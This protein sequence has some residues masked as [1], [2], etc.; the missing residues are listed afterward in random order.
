MKTI[1]KMSSNNN[2][3][4]TIITPTTSNSKIIINEN[5]ILI[6]LISGG[7]AG[8]VAKTTVAPFERLRIMAQTGHAHSSSTLISAQRIFIDEGI[9]GFW[10]GN[11]INV[12]R[13]T[14]ARGALFMSNDYFKSKFAIYLGII[15]SSSSS[16]SSSL[17]TSK[18]IASK[19]PPWASFLSGSFAGVVATMTTYPLDVARTRIAGRPAIGSRY[20]S[21]GMF[22]TLYIIVREE[23]IRGW[24]RGSGPTIAGALPYEGIKFSVYDLLKK[25]GPQPIPNDPNNIP[26]SGIWKLVS[27]ALAGSVAGLFMFPNDTVRKLLQMQGS[28]GAKQR[29]S[30]AFDCWRQTYRYGGIARFYRG[31]APYVIRMMPNSAIQFGTYEFVKTRLELS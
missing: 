15:P 22:R 17:A 16:S 19:L 13:I 4:N 11:F 20:V 9:K 6:S 23:G 7:I 5:K 21:A 29:Y 25:I 27:G 2:S 30:S 1:Q 12:V 18:H 31:V 28:D 24:Y 10:R 26:L 14:P 3:N 8:C